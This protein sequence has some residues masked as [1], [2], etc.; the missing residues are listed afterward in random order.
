LEDEG[1]KYVLYLRL[2]PK[3]DL[4][5]WGLLAGDC[6][7]CIRSALDHAVYGIAI[8]ES[9]SDP[10][11]DE[12]RLEFPITDDDAKWAD[13]KNRIK[14]LPQPVRDFI[15]SAQPYNRGDD[16]V[17]APLR[18]ARDLDDAD[19]HRLITPA[20]YYSK[21]AGV[22]IEGP[23]ILP[24]TY[25]FWFR[26]E[27]LENNAEI[28]SV[29]FLEPQP[30]MEVTFSQ[31]ILVGLGHDPAKNGATWSLF[32]TVLGAAYDEVTRIVD[33]LEALL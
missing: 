28:A 21:I 19:K 27:A 1:R 15:Y 6:I 11:P 33:E 13:R 16:L 9:G 12:R 32:T 23:A 30:G 17:V 22:R 3:P 26:H 31:R 24:L 4:V 14:T 18:W 20:L 25:H 5:R 7:H 8:A 29:T 2:S 10:P